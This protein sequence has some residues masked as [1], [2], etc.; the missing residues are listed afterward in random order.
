MTIAIIQNTRELDGYERL[1]AEVILRALRAEGASYTC[2][3]WGAHWLHLLG[4]DPAYVFRRWYENEVGAPAPPYE[5]IKLALRPIRRMARN[6]GD[7]PWPGHFS[8]GQERQEAVRIAEIMGTCAAA[9]WAGVHR[10]T[11]TRWRKGI[12]PLD[13]GE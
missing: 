4:L 13:A 10:H 11:V 2:S 6:G 9:K 8:S 1:I 5:P 7:K 12:A 3:P